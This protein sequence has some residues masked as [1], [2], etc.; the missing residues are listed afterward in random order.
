MNKK[1]IFLFFIV[2]T[3]LYSCK[4]ELLISDE[5]LKDLEVHDL[6]FEYLT[7]RSRI[8]YEDEDTRISA[9]ATIRI[10]KDSIIWLSLSPAFGIEAARGIITRDSI[11][12]IDRMN[13]EYA[14]YDF[15]S[16]SEEYNFNITFALIQSMLI[17]DMPKQPSEEDRVVKKRDH[18][19]IKQTRGPV[20]LENYIGS[21]M[22]LEKL[23]VTAGKPDENTLTLVYEDF[24][25]M[26]EAI[27]PYHSRVSLSYRSRKGPV[28]TLININHGKAEIQSES[29]SF[30]FDIPQKYERK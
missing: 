19:I 21:N 27:F 5:T 8:T 2:L 10:K 9:K 29:L 7:T 4:K 24:Q 13:R 20:T 1:K 25:K 15:A 22:K 12:F 6:D 16:L 30:P 23:Q 3:T 26:K 28:S 14:V 17:G 11:K 18:Y